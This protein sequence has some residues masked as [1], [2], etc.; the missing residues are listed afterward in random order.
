MDKF[1]LGNHN[2]ENNGLRDDYI[3]QLTD[4]TGMFQHSKGRLPDVAHGYTT[5]DNARALIMAIM[6]YEEFGDMNY[7]DLMYK[8]ASFVIKAQNEKGKFRNFMGSDGK[9]LER[10]GSE[11]CFGR[12]LWTLGIAVSNVW[13]PEDIREDLNK[14]LIKALKNVPEIKALRAKAYSIIGLACLDTEETK[15]LVFDMAIDICDSYEEFND[16]DWMWFENKL[17]YSNSILPWSLLAAYRLLGNWRFLDTALKSL[18]FLEKMVFRDGYFKPI[19]CKGWL[20]KGGKAA[21]YDEQPIEACETALMYLEAYKTTKDEKYK[22]MIEVCHSWYEG[23][24]SKGMSLIDIVTGGC[25]DG[26]M[27]NG[28]NINMGAESIISYSISYTLVEK[29]LVKI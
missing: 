29:R 15:K 16:R 7:L 6:L 19:G 3:F 5:D 11:D 12:C 14:L 8:Y 9:W 27:K 23:H 2:Y 28:H 4:E 25:F 21:E 18:K 17:T 22:K 1:F 13:T 24:N 20:E 26:L 10:E